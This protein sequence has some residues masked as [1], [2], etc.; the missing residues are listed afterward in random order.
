MA[1]TKQV[2][3]AKRNVKKAQAA[4]SRK[5]TIAHLDPATRRDLGRQAAKARQRGGQAGRNDGRWVGLGHRGVPA[6][7]LWVTRR[8][9]KNDRNGTMAASRTSTVPLAD[10]RAFNARS[11]VAR[12]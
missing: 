3:A 8:S 11:T 9:M 1:S 10:Q 5:R 6:W 7:T 2:R 12:K 4:A